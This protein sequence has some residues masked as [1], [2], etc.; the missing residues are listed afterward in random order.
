MSPS[1]PLALTSLSLPGSAL[2]LPLTAV[3]LPQAESPAA[4]VEVPATGSEAGGTAAKPSGGMNFLMPML[5]IFG[6]FWVVM[7]GPERKNR[8]RREQMISSLKKGDRVLTTSGMLGEVREVRD[9][10][11][12]LE[13]AEGVR[14]KFAIAAVQDLVDAKGASLTAPTPTNK[15]KEKETAAS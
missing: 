8:K 1:G 15:A 10:V 13:I 7:I 6:I 14:V 5:L 12:T 11:V 9:S 2:L 3:P 4:G